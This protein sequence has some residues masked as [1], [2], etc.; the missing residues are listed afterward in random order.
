MTRS[1]TVTLNRSVFAQLSFT[2]VL[3]QAATAG[4]GSQCVWCSIS[5]FGFCVSEDQA[6]TMKQQIPGLT[7]DDDDNG[8]D[9][10]DVNPD[11]DDDVAP[12]D[13]DAVPDD[14]WSCMKDHSTSADCTAAGCVWCVSES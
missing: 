12:D 3:E 13:D 6:Q 14:Y 1:P 5:T 7:C 8:N 9:D 10:D 4:D 2:P 11:D